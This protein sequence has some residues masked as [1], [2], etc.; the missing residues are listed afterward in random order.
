MKLDFAIG[1]II[2]IGVIGMVLVVITTDDQDG[3]S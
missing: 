2:F 1:L 3:N